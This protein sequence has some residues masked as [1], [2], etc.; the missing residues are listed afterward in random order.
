M[1]RP[2][3]SVYPSSVTSNNL[4]CLQGNVTYGNEHDISITK[5][6]LSINDESSSVFTSW[7]WFVLYVTYTGITYMTLPNSNSYR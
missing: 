3:L 2:I 1:R 7:V 4:E 5:L 6:T